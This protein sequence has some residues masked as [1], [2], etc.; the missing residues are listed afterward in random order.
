MLLLLL[1]QLEI[2]ILI[3][4]VVLICNDIVINLLLLVCLLIIRHGSCSIVV[5][6]VC[7]VGIDLQVRL[8]DI[9]AVRNGVE[10]VAGRGQLG[11]VGV[12]LADV[13]EFH[14]VFCL[15]W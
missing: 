15:S 5:S 7:V 8:W 11:L 6:I 12:E 1:L 13:G 10:R 14:S 9:V 3:I 4:I 2:V